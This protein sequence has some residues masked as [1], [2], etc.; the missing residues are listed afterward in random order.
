MLFIKV[1]F[2]F[3][4]FV[5][6]IR[7][8]NFYYLFIFCIN[9]L[10]FIGVVFRQYIYSSINFIFVCFV[11][12]FGLLEIDIVCKN[13]FFL[14]SIFNFRKKCFFV[15]LY[16][17]FCI[18][19]SILLKIDINFFIIDV[20]FCR[21]YIVFFFEYKSRFNILVVFSFYVKL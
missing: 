10:D 9:G 7:N 16:V 19:L 15:L 13:Y 11:E 18:N 21:V 4:L 3:Q 12:F 17:N 6:C 1:F 14:F 8:F 20:F 5:Y 2:C